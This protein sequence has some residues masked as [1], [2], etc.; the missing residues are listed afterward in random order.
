MAYLNSY[1]HFL[2]SIVSEIHPPAAGIEMLELG[3]QLIIDGGSTRLA[4]DYFLGLGIQYT[5]IDIHG[6]NG[7]VRKNLNKPQ[8]FE[9]WRE[10][11][12]IVTNIGTSEHVAKQYECFQTIHNVTRQNGLMVHIVPLA[13]STKWQNHSPYAYTHD[14][15][16][17]LADANGY[18]I[19][20]QETIDESVAIV[21]KRAG[22]FKTGRE[23]FKNHVVVREYR[24]SIR[25][26]I[27]S[28][29][30]RWGLSKIKRDVL[31]AL[32]KQ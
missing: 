31:A 11:F 13:E 16:K 17:R 28:F 7:A 18:L 23:F 21:L 14:F 10:R 2:E 9:S 29:V 8:Q 27:D 5:S 22:E 19:L 15:F 25:I 26:R 12:D 32:G 3:D 24:P 4:R 1:L 6:L 20:K 30:K